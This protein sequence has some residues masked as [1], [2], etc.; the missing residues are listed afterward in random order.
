MGNLRVLG[1]IKRG[2]EE[3]KNILRTGAEIK[4]KGGH[5]VRQKLEEREQRTNL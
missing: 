1:R 3:E 4:I 5:S 2:E